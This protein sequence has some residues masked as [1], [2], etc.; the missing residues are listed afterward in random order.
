MK[1]VIDVEFVTK[2]KF[3]VEADSEQEARDSIKNDVGLC[4]GGNIHTNMNDE[5]IDWDFET[6]FDKRILNVT[7][8]FTAKNFSKKEFLEMTD[9]H[10][11]TGNGRENDLSGLFFDWKTGD[12]DGKVFG[13]FKYCVWGR[14]SLTGKKKLEDQL[15]D[16]LTGKI[17][18]TE[19]YIQLIVAETDMQRFKV[20]IGGGFRN[21][22]KR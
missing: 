15:Y 10:K 12:I 20:P 18:D 5:D 6:H 14:T 8:K 17:Q 7:Q 11:M 19:Y 22:I 9:Y 2:G 4:L 13:G 16:F 1:Y 21:L 3:T